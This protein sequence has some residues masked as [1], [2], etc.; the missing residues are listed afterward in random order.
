M[1]D[2]GHIYLNDLV[3]RSLFGKI[4][5]GGGEFIMHNLIHDMA[6]LVAGCHKV[7]K[8]PYIGLLVRLRHLNIDDTSLKE[9]PPGIGK[10]INLQTLHKFAVA[11]GGGLRE[12]GKLNQLHGRL[13]IVSGLENVTEVDDAAEAQLCKKENLDGLNLKWG[14]CTDEVD[15]KTR[16]DVVEKLRPHTSIKR[17]ELDG[18]MGSRFPSWLGDSSFTNMEDLELKK[19][20]KCVCLPPL[21]QLSSLKSLLVEDMDGIKEEKW[22]HPSVNYKAFSILETLD[23]YNCPSLQGNLTSSFA[24]SYNAENRRIEK[25]GKA[26]WSI[27]QFHL[28]QLT[29]GWFT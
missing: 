27:A 18:Y 26:Y 16:I 5:Y 23:M 20:H 10:L 3:S 6:Q 29:R 19:C 17:C 11:I 9:M 24:F 15:D 1:E 14:T 2:M 22:V 25:Y 21:G 28:P 8:I 4:P 12:L 13:F 7:E